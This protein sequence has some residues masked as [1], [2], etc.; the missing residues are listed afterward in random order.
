MEVVRIIETVHRL[1][2]HPFDGSDTGRHNGY[3]TL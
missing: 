1:A 2:N 3:V